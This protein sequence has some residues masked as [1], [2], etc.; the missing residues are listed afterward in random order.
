MNKNMFWTM[1]KLS[2]APKRNPS[3]PDPELHP[4]V[5]KVYIHPLLFVALVL[6]VDSWQP[7]VNRAHRLISKRWSLSDSTCCHHGVSL[8]GKLCQ[9]STCSITLVD[10]SFTAVWILSIRSPGCRGIDRHLNASGLLFYVDA[11]GLYNSSVAWVQKIS[12]P[13]T[14]QDTEASSSAAFSSL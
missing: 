13:L 12:R 4:I 14:E 3:E 2:S 8:S 9:G 7:G 10:D 6:R 11:D 5:T 1:A